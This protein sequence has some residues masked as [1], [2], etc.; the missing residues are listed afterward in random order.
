MRQR[1]ALVTGN[2]GFIGSHFH[3]YLDW[4]DWNVKGFDIRG[5][6]GIDAV[7][8][9]RH[10][11]THYDL[12]VHAAA[13]IPDLQERERDAMPVASNI[14]LDSLMFQWAL[15]TQPTK[16]VYFS[17]AA[18][19]PI[20]LNIADRPLLEEDVDLDDLRQPD[21]MYGFSKLAGEYQAREARRQGLDVLVVR[22][23]TGYGVGQ[24]THY[25][26]P[27]MV[28][29]ARRREDPFVI[30]GSGNQVR[31]PVYVT[32]VIG[33]V[34]AMLALDVTG[35]VN[36]GSGEPWTVADIAKLVCGVSGYVPEFQF[37]TDKPEGSPA[38]YADIELM[39]CFYHP[40]TTLEQGVRQMVK[41]ACR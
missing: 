33:A 23:Q 34:M 27:A 29:R 1:T 26:I 10:D 11:H 9:F 39:T 38:R 37:L 2:A 32:D 8:F 17:S 7:E 21:G 18:A 36:I 12:V 40:K 15:R 3:R 41:V 19:Y 14:A 16:V 30:W 5:T 13:A 4:N 20:G 25:P 24:T 31:D 6:Y 28:E 22:P 35:P